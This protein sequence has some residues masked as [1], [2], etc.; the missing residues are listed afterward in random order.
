[1]KREENEE[2]LNMMRPL[3][4]ISV[5]ETCYQGVGFRAVWKCVYS[6]V[7]GAGS[8]VLMVPGQHTMLYG[9][10]IPSGSF[11]EM[12][13]TLDYWEKM[14][15]TF[16]LV[17]LASAIDSWRFQELLIIAPIPFAVRHGSF[18]LDSSSLNMWG[19][20]TKPA[21]QPSSA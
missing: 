4:G 3:Q 11:L 16:H 19:Y 7:E 1:M 14:P 8:A 10:R 13:P 5:S 6:P 2:T 20:C 9:G 21:L 12:K 17:S 15:V 18:F